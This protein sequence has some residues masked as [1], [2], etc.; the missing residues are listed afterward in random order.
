MTYELDFDFRALKEWKKLDPTIREH[1]R[2]KLAKRM[3]APRVPHD[4]LSGMSDHFKI[5]LRSSG[6]RLVYKVEDEVLVI[7]VV[8]IGKR[9]GGEVYD[10]AWQRSH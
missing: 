1:F 7:L 10:T 8:A 9:E 6:Y 2:K 4:A 5:K 3:T